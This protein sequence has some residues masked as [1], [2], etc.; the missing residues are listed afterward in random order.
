[1]P[2]SEGNLKLYQAFVKGLARQICAEKASPK[3]IAEYLEMIGD[4]P[5]M[6]QR[7]L[8]QWLW[9]NLIP[10]L[11]AI[12]I[13]RASKSNGSRQSA[14]E[15]APIPSRPAG[16]RDHIFLRWYET[17]GEVG[18]HSHAGIRDRWNREHPTKKIG[19]GEKSKG[20]DT[21]KKGIDKARFELDVPAG[22]RKP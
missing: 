3:R 8:C 16:E 14:P 5:P 9:N 18:Y 20:R 17:E 22:K 12:E 7:I 21:V 10:V 19:D 13:D 11:Q 2:E 1:M 6:D 4:F 15:P